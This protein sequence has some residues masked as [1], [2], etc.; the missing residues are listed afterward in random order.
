MA[1]RNSAATELAIKLFR[2]GKL[3]KY[4]AA[5]RAGVAPSTLYR[6]LK[7]PIAKKA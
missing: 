3:T 5:E 2:K 4:K 6:A 7:R 1:G